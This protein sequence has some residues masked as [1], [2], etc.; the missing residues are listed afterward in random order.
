MYQTKEHFDL[1][2]ARQHHYEM[3]I[4]VF[5]SLFLIIL[6]TLILSI[7]LFVFLKTNQF[8]KLVLALFISTLIV[9]FGMVTQVCING[10][11]FVE[12]KK[13]LKIIEQY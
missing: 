1:P 5:Y 7:L 11:L 2:I 9:G 13:R 6:F 3:T 12:K 10:D 8:Q 4:R